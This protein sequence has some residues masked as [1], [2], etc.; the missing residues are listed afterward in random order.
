MDVGTEQLFREAMSHLASGVAVVTT[1]R[2][3]GAPCGLAATSLTSYSAHPPSLLVSIWHGS[4]CHEALELC[5]HFGV[6]LLRADQLDVAHGF[7]DRESVD[8]F[9]RLDW[10]WDGDVPE[11]AQTLVYLRC[12]R[13][14]NFVR[15]DHT[16]LIGDLEAGRLEPGEPLVYSRRRMDWLMQPMR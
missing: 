1:R 3:D 11:L 15:Y 10:S 6:H 9:A 8:K 5:G 2:P 16:V 13:A 14:E 12:R 7:A 4:R